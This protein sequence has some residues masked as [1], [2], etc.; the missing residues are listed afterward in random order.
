MHDNDELASDNIGTIIILSIVLNLNF[1]SPTEDNEQEEN[2]NGMVH[3]S[4]I[5]YFY[6]IQILV[7][8]ESFAQV[9]S[10]SYDE[11]ANGKYI[12]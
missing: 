10:K 4:I 3:T 8:K 7:S 2:D 5:H 6:Y 9:M 11:T 1:H 12:H